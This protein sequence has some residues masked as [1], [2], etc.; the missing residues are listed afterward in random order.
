MPSRIDEAGHTKAFDYP[1]AQ[2]WGES[3]RTERSLV[4]WSVD[5]QLFTSAEQYDTYHKA[6]AAKDDTN[7]SRILNTSSPA[8]IKRIGNSIHLAPGNKWNSEKLQIM[9]RG[10]LEKFSQNR[11]LWQFLFETGEKDLIEAGPDTYWGAGV[12]LDSPKLNDNSWGSSFPVFS[13]VMEKVIYTRCIKFLGKNNIFYEYQFGFRQNHSSS[14]AL[15]RLLFMRRGKKQFDYFWTFRRLL[16]PSIII[17]C[18]KSWNIMELKGL[19]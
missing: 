19:C 11:H 9:K 7:A 1:V 10:C 5:G 3:Q 16:T 18:L 14:H 12:K 8:S 15:S 4:G 6:V 2:H 13:K 17:Y